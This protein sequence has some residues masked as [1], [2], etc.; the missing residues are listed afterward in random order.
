MKIMM[1]LISYDFPP[2]I[3]VEK[4]A[5]ALLATGHQITLVCENRKDRPARELWNGIEIIRLPLQPLWWR[6]INTATL[7]ITLRS[8]LWEW[9]VKKIVQAEKPDVIHVH[10]LSFVG[11]GLRVARKFNLPIVADLHETYPEYLQL[12]RTVSRNLIEWLS[13]DPKRFARYEQRVIPRCDYVI[14]VVEEAAERIEKLGVGA[15]KIFVVGNTED[16][17]AVGPSDQEVALPHSEMKLLYVGGIGPHRGLDTVIKAMPRILERIPSSVL[18]IVGDGLCLLALKELAR[19]LRVEQAVQFEGRQPFAKVHSYIKA[20]DVCLVPHV[21]NPFT[22]TTMPHK[23]FQY[24]YMQK[25]VIVSSAKPLARVVRESESGLVFDSGDS[26]SFA[27]SVFE[28]QAQALRR[29]LGENGHRAVVNCYNWQ[30]DSRELV[31]LYET[32]SDRQK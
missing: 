7:F 12:R 19:Q 31:R 1:L 20:S 16:V 17:D 21:A 30:R 18:V 5:R 24:M 27:K 23:L 25:P 22:D 8:P 13:F 11:P 32:L 4:E 15:G 26:A 29:R 28:L 9:H 14:V 10:D 3:R 2:D 6:R